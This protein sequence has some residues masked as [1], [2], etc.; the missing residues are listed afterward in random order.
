MTSRLTIVSARYAVLL[1]LTQGLW[2]SAAVAQDH[3]N[4]YK[5]QQLAAV[6]RQ[7]Q[8]GG[9]RIV[10]T[11]AVV[12]PDMRVISEPREKTARRLLDEL[13]APHG[14]EAQEGPGGVIQVIRRKPLDAAKREKTQKDPVERLR[15]D[16]AG[17][18]TNE[19]A[20]FSERVTVTS[21]G[22][23]YEDP[24][25]HS[26]LTLGRGE[27]ENLSGPLANDPLRAVH[28]LPRVATGDD[29]RS[30]F[31][32]RGS[33]YRHVGIV[34]DGV[35]TPWLQHAVYGRRDSGSI[36]MLTSEVV[37]RAT[38][39]AGAY[40]HRYGD[41]L[42]A[43]LGLT[44]R[45][46][47]RVLNRFQ[48]ALGGAS[49]TLLG[50][51]PIGTERRGSWLV[52]LRQSYLNWPTRPVTKFGGSLFGFTDTH[53]KLVYDV[54][55]TQQASLTVLAGRSSV[56]EWE[57]QGPTELGDGI[58]RVA[59]ANFGWRSTLSPRVVLSQRAY[60]VARQFL[61]RSPD[62]KD[63]GGGDDAEVSY[64]SDLAMAIPRGVL[65]AGGQAQHIRTSRRSPQYGEPAE[66][67]IRP[68]L[69]LDAFQGSSWLRSGYA[70]VR[71]SGLPRLTIA[72]GL[73]VGESTLVNRPSVARWMLGEWSLRPDWT[74]NVSGGVSHQFPEFD[75]TVGATGAAGLRPERAT[76]LDIGI[77]RQLTPT[78]RS[79]ATV[80]MRDESDV[81]RA[82]DVNARIIDRV[83]VDPPRSRRY[84]NALSG[85]SRGVELLLERRSV[86]GISGWVAYSYGKTRHIDTARNE[87][88]WG[89]FDQR[90]AINVAGIYRRSSRTAFA[91]KFRGGTNFPIPGYFVAREGRLFAGMARNDVRL[92]GYAR[93]DVRASRTFTYLSRR[94]TVFAEML[95]V[96]DRTNMRPAN[97]IIRRET[98]EA[99]GF[100]EELF[101][102]LP[103]AGLVIDF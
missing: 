21:P 79:Q 75:H 40:P 34:V 60:V 48:A 38:L 19:T 61:N 62:D 50:E 94:V 99:I 15:Q 97:G 18:T 53:A 57:D 81:L 87:S 74:V 43:Q 103:S 92:P 84:E 25:V 76:H 24:G 2:T 80:F 93:L 64:R 3:T 23:E 91:V 95:N 59:V 33:P 68:L 98:G 69:S 66:E 17:R 29:F 101:P 32:V 85:S 14:L 65:E 12:T 31:S 39:Q 100:T 47:S 88:F 20:R 26:E 7:L 1:L 71:W 8:A 86:T 27:L 16:A 63:R 49:G 42:G 78:I 13:L 51:G 5:G 55:S 83:L 73:R 56:A 28:A 96:L 89:D 6:L 35:S 90:H 45:E 67:N 70:H 54:R 22:L 9:L 30:D 82:P 46:G 102:R 72:S 44:M 52:T 10:F 77:E 58:N 41:R 4:K 11:S 36:G 37:E